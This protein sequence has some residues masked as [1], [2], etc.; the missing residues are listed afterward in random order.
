MC[1][2][3]SIC[4][5]VMA[6][7]SL[8][9]GSEAAID[10]SQ[11][12]ERLEHYYNESWRLV[13]IDPAQAMDTARLY[14]RLAQAKQDS[15]ELGYAYDMLGLC[16]YYQNHNDSALHYYHR[17]AAVFRAL[18]DSNGL[19]EAL[20]YT[21]LTQIYRGHFSEALEAFRRSYQIDTTLGNPSA[22]PFYHF[23]LGTLLNEQEAYE[24]ALPLYRKALKAMLRDSLHLY[25]L[26]GL[27]ISIAECLLQ[28]DKLE[29]ARDTAQKA[30]HTARQYED[31]ASLSTAYALISGVYR[32]K[33]LYGPAK[34]YLDSAYSLDTAFGDPYTLAYDYREYALL[35][36]AEGRIKKAR[37]YIHRARD[38][39]ATKKVILLRRDV[40]ETLAQVEEAAGHLD[41]A[42]QAL[43]RHHAIMDTLR[44]MDTY[45]QIFQL[46]KQVNQ[47][48]L[49]L[50]QAQRKL[51]AQK[52][53]RK[54]NYLRISVIALG[55]AVLL[56]VIF[57]RMRQRL[58]RSN[59][60]LQQRNA[61]IEKQRHK[62]DTIAE[63]LRHQKQSLEKL[64]QSKNRLFSILA[65]DLKQPFLQLIQ[66]I[67]MLGKDDMN[68][69][70][71]KELLQYL[72]QNVQRT[73]EMVNN[74]LTW[75]K[76]QFAGSS[77]E[78]Q[79]VNLS[80]LVKKQVLQMSNLL[81]EKQLNIK[82]DLDPQIY[83][84]A[85]PEHLAIIVRNMLH[86]ALKYSYAQGKIEL[87]ASQKDPQT[88]ALHLRDYGRGMPPEKV[89]EL[90]RSHHQNSQPGTLMESGTGLGLLI[91]KE[92][93]AENQGQ[94][95]IESEPEQGSVFTIFLP[96]STGQNTND[97]HSSTPQNAFS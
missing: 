35:H 40:Y 38:M 17:A 68:K 42:Y 93:L 61:K 63:K 87:T 62:L 43:K 12:A 81:E 55:L 26:P 19:S 22:Q 21:G 86:N 24:Q 59:A 37:E 95:H 57:Y 39:A 6:F 76:A 73:S 70:E 78:P 83:V 18:P 1:L 88:I 94:L 15:N 36:L 47:K 64:N 48:E 96:I 41:K 46:E 80:A 71:R 20:Y 97:T 30:M 51:Q 14:Y 32:E 25:Q 7:L 89:E 13:A 66:T 45:H 31:Q 82:I 58:K 84:W 91:I 5:A 3:Q 69:V 85:D 60:E 67:E 44:P 92:L 49:A 29:A 34:S 9:P 54:N 56:L 4:T 90:M 77:V 33:G 65:H 75:S 16:H 72:K 28:M 53:D 50:S 52:L 74:L 23:N 27:Y 79:E 8:M 2:K 11:S 10:T